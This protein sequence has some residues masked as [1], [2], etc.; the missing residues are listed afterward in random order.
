MPTIELVYFCWQIPS[1][2]YKIAF[3]GGNIRHLFANLI[4]GLIF[5]V[6]S[7]GTKF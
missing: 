7:G 4:E 2:I 5:E 1:Q 3:N 6:L